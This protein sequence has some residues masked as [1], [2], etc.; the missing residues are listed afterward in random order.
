MGNS[1]GKED[2]RPLHF[3]YTKAFFIGKHEVSNAEYMKFVE[4]LRG[5]WMVLQKF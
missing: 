5:L 2:E 3:V 4:E 1:S